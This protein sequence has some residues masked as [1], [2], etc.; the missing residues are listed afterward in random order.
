MKRNKAENEKEGWGGG[1]S[2]ASTPGK[3]HSRQREGRVQCPEVQGACL[4]HW[5]QEAALPE[6]SEG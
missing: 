3:E 6:Q 5:K 2:R 4:E 1:W